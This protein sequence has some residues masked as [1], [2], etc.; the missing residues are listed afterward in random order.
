MKRVEVSGCKVTPVILYG[1]VSPEGWGL[2]LGVHGGLQQVLPR[3][4]PAGAICTLLWGLGV[5]F[6]VLGSGFWGFG[7]RV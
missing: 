6:G 1:V 7:L 2:G 3:L 5:G 4:S